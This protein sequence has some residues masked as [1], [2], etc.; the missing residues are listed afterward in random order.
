VRKW[1]PAIPLAALVALGAL[2]LAF[3]LSLRARMP[4][5]Q[6]WAEAAAALRAR[7]APG[8]AVQLWPPWADRARMFVDA[9]PVLAEEDLRSAEYVGVQR[10]WLLSLPSSPH[11]RVDLAQQALRARGAAPVADELRFGALSLQPWDLRP[12]PLAADLTARYPGGARWVEVDYVARRCISLWV[13]T[14]DRPTRATVTGPAGK[15]LHLRAGIVGERAF[16]RARPPVGLIARAGGQRLA[17][18]VVPPIER[19]EPGWHRAEV[20]LPPG[21]D[22]REFT[23]EVASPDPAGRAFCVQAWTTR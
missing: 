8:D 19:F 23:F 3:D 17:Q 13:G 9:L 21:P 15:V 18:L 11:A 22:E 16:D 14:P 12:A 6:D 4:S 2:S 1:V 10:L 7:A 20:Q 5:T